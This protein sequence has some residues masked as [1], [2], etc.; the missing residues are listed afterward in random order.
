MRHPLHSMANQVNLSCCQIVSKTRN[1][2]FGLGLGVNI[3]FGG[4]HCRTCVPSLCFL[5]S[6]PVFWFSDRTLA[7]PQECF[8][9][10]KTVCL[11]LI[12]CGFL[13]DSCMLQSLVQGEGQRKRSAWESGVGTTPAWPPPALCPCAHFSICEMDNEEEKKLPRVTASS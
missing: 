10:S 12:Q 1:P 7:C 5:A 3:F 13:Q 4:R 6:E 2:E 11:T 9:M 8:Q